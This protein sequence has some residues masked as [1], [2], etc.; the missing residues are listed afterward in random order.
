M[1]TSDAFERGPVADALEKDVLVSEHAAVSRLR[2]IQDGLDDWEEHGR[3]AAIKF[4][5]LVRPPRG[6]YTE[7]HARA[8]HES[9]PVLS[10]P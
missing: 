9:Q 7:A 6:G 3:C 1:A 10:D 8:W 4:I 5:Y 2:P